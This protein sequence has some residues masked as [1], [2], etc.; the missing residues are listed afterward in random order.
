M[1]QARRELG[2]AG[3]IGD[4]GDAAGVEVTGCDLALACDLIIAS[5]Q[6][7]FGQFWVRRGL[8]PDLGAVYLLRQDGDTTTLERASIR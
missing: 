2:L 4:A 3:V 5:E 1:A 8:V 6:A 7:Q